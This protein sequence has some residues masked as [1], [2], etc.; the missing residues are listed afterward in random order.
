MKRNRLLIL[1][2]ILYLTNWTVLINYNSSEIVDKTHLGVTVWIA[3]VYALVALLKFSRKTF[4]YHR[5]G[6][7]VLR[8][9]DIRCLF[10]TRAYLLLI[11]LLIRFTLVFEESES[12]KLTFARLFT[13]KPIE[14]ITSISLIIGKSGGYTVAFLFLLCIVIEQFNQQINHKINFNLNRD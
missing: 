5:H 2:L 14:E 9:G 8:I 11:P 13:D 4:C 3:F 1:F 6:I 12:L 7:R 10:Q